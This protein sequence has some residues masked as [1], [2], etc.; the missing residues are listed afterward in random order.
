MLSKFQDPVR[1]C[2]FGVS[3]SFVELMQPV[4]AKIQTEIMIFIRISIG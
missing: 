1:S 4:K 2:G 3:G